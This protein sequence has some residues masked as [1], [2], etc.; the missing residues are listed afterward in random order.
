[1]KLPKY[2]LEPMP[3]VSKCDRAGVC[4]YDFRCSFFTHNC[5]HDL[6]VKTSGVQKIWRLFG[7]GRT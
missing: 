2:L 4:R 1:M 7:R 5:R 3:E 6:P